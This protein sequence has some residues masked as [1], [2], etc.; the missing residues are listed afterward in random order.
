MKKL[1]MLDIDNTL[2][3]SGSYRNKFFKDIALLL[4]REK[5][6][7]EGEQLV[8]SIYDRL[9]VKLGM[10]SPHKF[11]DQVIKE[12]AIAP[13]LREEITEK[14]FSQRSLKNNMHIEVQH[15][16]L[17]LEKL[18]ELGIFSQGDLLLQKAKIEEIKHLFALDN[19]HI[20]ENKIDVFKKIFSMYSGYKI[21]FIDDSLPILFEVKKLYKD[22]FA[23]WIKRGRWAE[24][25][26]DIPGFRPDA[27]I[28]NLTEAEELVK[29]N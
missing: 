22:I 29:N 4:K 1:V 7:V 2:F 18:A 21:F 28:L 17:V 24:K 27:I 14:I 19:V 5:N 23:I 26:K 25:Q 9:R 8:S 16:L 20:V 13:S 15:A 12:T 3:D 10:F 6:I 11:V